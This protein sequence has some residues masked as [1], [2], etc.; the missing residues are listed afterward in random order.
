MSNELQIFEKLSWNDKI[1]YISWFYQGMIKKTDNP[2]YIAKFQWKIDEV[3]TYEENEVNNSNLVSLYERIMWAKE[4]TKQRK[5]EETKKT[6]EKKKQKLASIE[7]NIEDKD[8][9][10]YLAQ[11]ITQC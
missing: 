9:D 1:Q 2:E 7:A 5:I 3:R 10:E 8:S 6:I 11:A 4:K